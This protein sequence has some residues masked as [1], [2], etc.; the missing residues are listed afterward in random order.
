MDSSAEASR[1]S[2]ARPAEACV[3]VARFACA[4]ASS[5]SPKCTVVLDLHAH[6][7]AAI[8]SWPSIATRACTCVAWPRGRIPVIIRG[9]VCREAFRW[10]LY[11]RSHAKVQN[12]ERGGKG[13]SS[14]GPRR[15]FSRRFPVEGGKFIEEIAFLASKVRFPG[16]IGSA[17]GRDF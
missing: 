8:L 11:D 12:R 4:L 10:C 2:L 15:I 14:P 7:G 17:A 6:D 1:V 5:P 9:G 16:K 3:T 13:F